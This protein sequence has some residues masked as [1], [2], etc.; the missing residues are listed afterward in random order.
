M[1]MGTTEKKIAVIIEAEADAQQSALEIIFTQ[2]VSQ[3]NWQ[4]FENIKDVPTTF[5]KVIC[6]GDV[7]V[8]VKF[9]KAFKFVRFPFSFALTKKNLTEFSEKLEA[10]LTTKKLVDFEIV[11]SAARADEVFEYCRA[12]GEFAFDFETEGLNWIVDRPT[13]LSITFQAGYSYIIPIYHY[14]HTWDEGELECIMEG[15]I[16]LMMDKSVTK[17]GHNV[18]FDL[19]VYRQHFKGS[20]RGRIVD[21]MLQHHMLD[22]N[23][24]QD[25]ET[26]SVKFFPESA[27]YSIDP[28]NWAMVELNELSEYAAIDTNNTY[29]IYVL[30]EDLLSLDSALYHNYRNIVI[31]TLRALQEAE[32]TG[33]L[34]DKDYVEESITF[35]EAVAVELEKELRDFNEVKRFENYI[36]AIQTRDE[37][38][39]IESKAK[40]TKLDIAK[41][42][43]LR[44]NPDIYSI[45]FSSTKQLGELLYTREGFGFKQPIDYKTKQPTKSTGADALQDIDSPFIELLQAYRSVLKTISTYYIGILERI[46]ADNR[47]HST[48]LLHG[49]TTGRLSSRNPNMQNLPA[50]AKIKRVEEVVKRVKAF[51]VAPEGMD[52]VQADLSQAELRMIASAAHDTNMIDAYNAGIDLHTTT[53]ARLAGMSLEK[54]LELPKEE[55]NP[56]RQ[57]AKSAN[58]GYV[59]GLSVD[60]Y[61]AY[62]KLT[63]GQTITKKVAEEHRNAIFGVY[64]KLEQ[65]HE[66]YVA[67]AK[68]EGYVRTL[69]GRKRR[70]PNINDGGRLGS[71]AEKQA[72]NSPIQGSSAEWCNLILALGYLIFPDYVKFFN[73]I[74]DAVYFYSPTDKTQFIIEQVNELAERLPLDDIF[75]MEKFKVPMGLEFEVSDTNWLEVKKVA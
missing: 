67:F 58:F 61:I 55:R 70:L 56:F 34:I 47:L 21:T 3:K 18:K 39:R 17:V 71:D 33:A 43:K 42:D 74:H 45:N 65:W 44:S 22:E 72:I 4:I 25:L 57:I 63:T 75:D 48:F 16:E 73:S 15:F 53:G 35:A 60:G 23:S 19:H 69:F 41:L 46:D 50:R 36:T 64:D 54:F 29:K 11:T 52:L 12:A 26:V 2:V 1:V 37:I 59:Y 38:I 40:H 20:Y 6:I 8:P 32:F 5:S 62:V 7:K 31:P 9:R 66:T 24:L 30:F 10:A 13:V 51:F 49:T 68:Q 14:Q 28:A 27:G